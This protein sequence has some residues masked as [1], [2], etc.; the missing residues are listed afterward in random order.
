[1][2]EAPLTP[3]Q[4]KAARE[5]LGWSLSALAARVGVRRATVWAFETGKEPFQVLDLGIVRSALETVGVIFVEENGE[6]PGVRL[7]KAIAER[8]NT[9]KSL[10]V[11]RHCKT[12][13]AYYVAS[14]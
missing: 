12:S 13:L 10:S 2:S 4:V 9:Q 6:G 11:K 3:A 5:L 1:M 14:N 7:R 8:L